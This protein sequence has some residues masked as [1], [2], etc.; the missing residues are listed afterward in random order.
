MIKCLKD[1]SVRRC[2][3]RNIA[4]VISA[5]RKQL[6]QRRRLINR[7][8][9]R[10]LQKDKISSSV[11]MMGGMESIK[12]TSIGV[13]LKVWIVRQNPNLLK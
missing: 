9:E 11:G 4:K 2:Y 5:G 12:G 3:D 13:D 8:E 10:G 7:S 6:R 1:S